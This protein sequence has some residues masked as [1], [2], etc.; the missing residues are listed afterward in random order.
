[1]FSSWVDEM[2]IQ[3]K[4][5]ERSRGRLAALYS[6]ALYQKHFVF[7]LCLVRMCWLNAYRKPRSTLQSF[8]LAAKHVSGNLSE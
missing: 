8:G 3:E 2:K 1:M 7:Q 4:N 6:R 5:D